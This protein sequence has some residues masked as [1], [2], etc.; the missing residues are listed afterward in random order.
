MDL[1]LTEEQALALREQL[2]WVERNQATALCNS[3]ALKEV[4]VQ[5]DARLTPLPYTLICA[6][7]DG[8]GDI[9]IYDA[10]IVGL[11]TFDKAQAA[12]EEQRREELDGN[13]VTEEDLASWMSGF[14]VKL[15]YPGKLT[16]AADWRT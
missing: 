15:V 10:M 9:L 16:A 12:A 6:G 2:Q 14:E 5:L 3:A 4:L 1:N 7:G 11:P 13:G 8:A